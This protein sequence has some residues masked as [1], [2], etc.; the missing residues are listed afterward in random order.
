MHPCAQFRQENF[1]ATVTN[2]IGYPRVEYF[3]FIISVFQPKS[4][5][6]REVELFFLFGFSQ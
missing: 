4:Q 3:P 2:D 1:P 5:F 6:G